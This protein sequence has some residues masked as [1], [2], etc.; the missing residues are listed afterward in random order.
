MHI[1][2]PKED[3]EAEQDPDMLDI[4]VTNMRYYMF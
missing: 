4:A 3:I 2:K 1:Q